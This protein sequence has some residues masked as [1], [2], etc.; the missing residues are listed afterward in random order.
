MKQ[1]SVI[2]NL[3]ISMS[4][5]TIFAAQDEENKFW[6]IS[7]NGFNLYRRQISFDL[8][9]VFP[10]HWESSFRHSLNKFYYSRKS[11]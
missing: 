8:S 9:A 7:S 3:A 5:V 10:Y 2:L 6:R 11:I 1:V 4:P